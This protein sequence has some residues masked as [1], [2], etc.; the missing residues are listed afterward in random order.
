[1]W[2]VFRP[3]TVRIGG[4]LI[5]VACVGDAFERAPIPV[6]RT[7][8]FHEFAPYVGCAVVAPLSRADQ[9]ARSEVN[10]VTLTSLMARIAENGRA[11]AP[12]QSARQFTVVL[13]KR[14]L[15]EAHRIL[16]HYCET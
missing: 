7:C 4:D 12:Q 11:P 5:A 15:E 13:A 10:E 16:A 9:R 1:M 8:D 3:F 6:R 14:F 2:D